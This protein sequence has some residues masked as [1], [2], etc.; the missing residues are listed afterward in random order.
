M[1]QKVPGDRQGRTYAELL[2]LSVVQNAIKGKI[3]AAVEVTDRVEGKAKQGIEL[4]GPGG[5]A[6]PVD[7]GDPAKNEAAIAALLAKAGVT[8]GRSKRTRS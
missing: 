4:G 5:G 3:Q 2:A 1:R 6:I 7:V 8:I